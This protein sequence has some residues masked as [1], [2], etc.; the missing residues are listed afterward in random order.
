MFFITEG[1]KLRCP[2]VIHLKEIFV[3][4]FNFQISFSFY[5][6]LINQIYL[7]VDN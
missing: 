4:V 7:F 1:F 6:Q 3:P 5:G 2:N